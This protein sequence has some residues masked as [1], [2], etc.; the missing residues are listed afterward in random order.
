M[1]GKY[2]VQWA[3]G[4]SFQ[5]FKKGSR[6]EIEGSIDDRYDGLTVYL[7]DTNTTATREQ[8]PA[9]STDGYTI[10]LDLGDHISPGHRAVLVEWQDPASGKWTV[11]GEVF[12]GDP[13]GAGG[14]GGEQDSGTP[15]E[16]P[17]RRK[18]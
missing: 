5:V 3:N 18:G 15:E 7:D 12:V 14:F 1:A 6:I 11:F 9:V 17:E 16:E 4:A 2:D 13:D 8:V 10:Q